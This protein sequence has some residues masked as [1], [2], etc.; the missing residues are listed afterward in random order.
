MTLSFSAAEQAH[1][2][3]NPS[4]IQRSTPL[5]TFMP[6]SST[7]WRALAATTE[8]PLTDKDVRALAALGDPI[9]ITEADAVY[10]PLSALMQM[11]ARHTGRLMSESH[12]FI[13]LPEHRTPWIIGIAGS[14][15]AGKSTAARLLRELMR[16]W[17][18]TPHVDLVTT[19]GFL[20]PNATLTK[21]GLMD[22]KGFPESYDRHAL[23]NFLSAVKSGVGNLRVPVY[24]HI[25]YDIVPGK[26]IT[27]DHPD[28]LIVEGLN[29]LQPPRMSSSD[30]EF[31]AVSD[32]FDFSIYLD[33]PEDALEQWY[34]DRFRNLR[35][36]AFTHP[37]SFFRSYA[38]L[39]DEE[40]D[41]TA[42]R[43]WRT[44][45]L[46]NLRENVAPTRSR[47]TIILTKGADH[48]VETIYLRKL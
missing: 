29:V 22:R 35:K 37:H 38:D 11:Y 24:D 36:T 14:V 7:K 13:G 46:P 34:M 20:Y 26:W 40:A 1:G 19:D 23:L 39:S 42:R 18:Q 27:V 15:A 9:G 21:H 6:I 30:G 28:V 44:I 5:S 33:A 31:R 17:P 48:S 41:N 10:R 3:I 4:H 32:Y 12:S 25:S 8:L 43:L 47:A 2:P 16:R 45:N